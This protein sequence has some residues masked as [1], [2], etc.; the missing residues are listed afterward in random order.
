MRE[1]LF[2]DRNGLA[3]FLTYFLSTLLLF[4]LQVKAL[5]VRQDHSGLQSLVKL[6]TAIGAMLQKS[7]AE[8]QGEE[9]AAADLTAST[10]EAAGG[11]VEAVPESTNEP[12]MEATDVAASQSG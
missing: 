4:G 1:A 12:T 6:E 9:E 5:D 3:D 10:F 7:A 8:R 11:D 2:E